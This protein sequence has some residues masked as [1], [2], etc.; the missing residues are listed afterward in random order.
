MKVVEN[1]NLSI[2]DITKE[3]LEKRA[4][5]IGMTQFHEWSDRIIQGAMVDAT[6]RSLK[7][8]LA[9]MIFHLQPTEDFKEDAHFIKKLRKGAVNETAAAY[10][11]HIKDE[12]EEEK[13]QRDKKLSEGIQKQWAEDTASNFG[14]V[15][16][17]LEKPTVQ[18][19]VQFVES[20]T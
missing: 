14:V 3:M 2:G 9:E 13:R 4:L 16:G 8:A 12:Q 11:R 17:I 19:P 1:E 10:M 6:P 18:N 20:K 7:W 5:P 15:D